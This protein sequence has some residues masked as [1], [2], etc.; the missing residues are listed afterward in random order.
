MLTS[1]VV[2]TACLSPVS[3]GDG[4]CAGDAGCLTPASDGI[5]DSGCSEAECTLMIQACRAASWADPNPTFSN[6]CGPWHAGLDPSTIG[7]IQSSYCV[8][9]CRALPAAATLV[10]CLS[11]HASECLN[12]YDAGRT[13]DDVF[14]ACSPDAGQLDQACDDRCT[15]ARTACQAG[16]GGGASCRQCLIAGQGMADCSSVCPDGGYLGCMDCSAACGLAFAACAD[17]CFH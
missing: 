11:E 2:V 10:V 15:A 12:D 13:A 4:G 6:G 8:K 17:G 7:Q 9:T 16:C 1:A 14:A 5:V 3:T